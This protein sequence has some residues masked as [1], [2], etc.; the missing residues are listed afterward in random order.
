MSEQEE[1]E[2]TIYHN[3]VHFTAPI[4]GRERFLVER[5][6]LDDLAAPQVGRHK[7]S[8]PVPDPET[9]FYMLDDQ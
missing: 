6:F 8:R 2:M 3:G 4:R 9:D 1:L 5:A 7:H